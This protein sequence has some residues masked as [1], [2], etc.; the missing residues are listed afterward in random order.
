MTRQLYNL[1]FRHNWQE[2][3]IFG[4]VISRVPE[5]IDRINMLQHRVNIYSEFR[6][7]AGTGQHAIT[8]NVEVPDQEEN[9]VLEWSNQQATALHDIILLLSLFSGREVFLDNPN[10]ENEPQVILADPRM[11]HYGGIL[12]CSIPEEFE[13]GYS[14]EEGHWVREIAFERE[15]NAMYE[16]IRCEEWQEQYQRGFVLFLAKDAFRLQ[17]IESAFI[18]CWTIWEHLFAVLNR[19]WMSRREIL[20]ISSAEK[21][22]FILV[23]FELRDQVDER[24]RR[25]IESLT[26]MHNRLIHYG[27]FPE[28]DSV[29]ENA[30][31]F[32]RLTESVIS[33]I[34]GL[35][36]SNLF[37]TV[38]LLEEF[39]Q[40]NR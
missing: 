26:Q 18:Q 21:I 25:Q 22:A 19:R 20:R 24:S 39:L 10:E 3:N 40:Q 15:F 27:R 31:L 4:Y 29:Q 1:E 11:W 37:N 8:A 33:R 28:R 6:I 17:S 23:R 32:V 2:F 36:P 13:R 16:R 30:D 5:Y 38:E 9:A 34:L 14:D 12:R 35:A 7:T